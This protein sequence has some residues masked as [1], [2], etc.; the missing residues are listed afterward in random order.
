MFLPFSLSLCN[1][2]F[3]AAT[4]NKPL[5]EVYSSTDLQYDLSYGRPV[6]PRGP[7]L[8]HIP[9]PGAGGRRRRGVSYHG[10]G[11]GGSGIGHPRGHGRGIIGGSVGGS[12]GGPPHQPVYHGHVPT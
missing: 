2:A 9:G 5:I 6:D 8:F 7:A 1:S 10:G 3:N 4:L 11:K 12:V